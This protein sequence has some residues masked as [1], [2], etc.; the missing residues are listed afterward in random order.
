M[1]KQRGNTKSM[2]RCALIFV[3]RFC[4]RKESTCVDIL[5]RPALAFDSPIAAS[6]QID[7]QTFLSSLKRPPRCLAEQLS[8]EHTSMLLTFNLEGVDLS[9]SGMHTI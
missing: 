8:K 7:Y 3:L 1:Q 9:D 4:Y 2:P 5:G 6:R